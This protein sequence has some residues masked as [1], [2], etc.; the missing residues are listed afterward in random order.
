MTF[1]FTPASHILVVNVCLGHSDVSTTMNI[2]AHSTRKAKRDFARL[3]DKVASNAL[4]KISLIPLRIPHKG[5]NKGK[6]IS[7]HY[8]MG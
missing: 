7:F 3:L 1:I 5:K 8:I 6:Y 2:Y 4:T